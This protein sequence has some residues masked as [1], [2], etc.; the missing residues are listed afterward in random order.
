MK[1]PMEETVYRACRDVMRGT[2]TLP[3]AM[4]QVWHAARQEERL[5][6]ERTKMAERAAAEIRR[7]S[8]VSGKGERR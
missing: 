7:L 2:L 1:I 5:D 8:R 3:E 6:G 4:R